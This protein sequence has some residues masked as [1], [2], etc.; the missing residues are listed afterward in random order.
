MYA[1]G[2]YFDAPDP[3]HDQATTVRAI[4]AISEYMGRYPQ[5]T[6]RNECE[7]RTQELYKKL[8]TK[9]YLNAKLYYTIRQYKAAVRALN[10]AIDEYPLS[11]YR[12]ELMYLATRSAW[13]F[14][15]NSVTSQQ[16]DRYLSM[17]DNYLNLVSQYPE[18][19]YIDEV[20]KMADE[21]QKYIDEN[22]KKQEDQ[23]NGN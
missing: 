17:M 19:E 7:E 14:A 5:T 16:T 3:E 22:T 6:K 8:Y 12:E 15:K 20:R 18:S 9:S 4:A 10:N 1:M 23:Q 2:Y 21:A 11:P 13:L